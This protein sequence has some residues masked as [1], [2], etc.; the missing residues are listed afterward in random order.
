MTAFQIEA[1]GHTNSSLVIPGLI[2]YFCVGLALI[3]AS[4]C[5]HLVELSF[6]FSCMAHAI[7]SLEE[8][9]DRA[10]IFYGEFDLVM[11]FRVA[12][13]IDSVSFRTLQDSNPQPLWCETVH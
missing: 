2:F 13:L 5:H 4:L 7:P 9:K 10:P 8:T 6:L 1:E 11:C 3:F 12:G